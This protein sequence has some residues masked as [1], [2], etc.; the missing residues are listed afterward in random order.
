MSGGADFLS[1]KFVCKLNS[2]QTKDKIVKTYHEWI[3]Y[4]P[5]NS[6][7][8]EE[9]TGEGGEGKLGMARDLK[10]FL[11]HSMDNFERSIAPLL[12]VFKL[13]SLG[14][15]ILGGADLRSMQ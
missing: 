10:L 12:S 7:D 11:G 4:L 9:R 14:W 6:I 5:L 8:L 2:V 1:L 15:V 3:D 13:N